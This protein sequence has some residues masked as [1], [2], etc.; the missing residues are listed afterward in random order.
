MIG[1]CCPHSPTGIPAL[2]CCHV[3]LRGQKPLPSTYPT[4]LHTFSDHLRKRRLDL[5]LLQREAAEQIGVDTTTITNW[6]LGHTT[7]ALCW[8]P[9]VTQFLGYDPAPKPE[10][11]GQS[12]KRYRQRHGIPQHELANRLGVDPGTL[13]RWERGARQPTGRWLT[14]VEAALVTESA[15]QEAKRRS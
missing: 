11:I 14:R 10:T 7:P 12:L 13:G 6:E 15:G 1:S 9:N 8:M 4:E 2:P 5:G 3:H